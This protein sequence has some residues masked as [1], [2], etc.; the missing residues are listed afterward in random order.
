MESLTKGH[1]VFYPS[2]LFKSNKTLLVELVDFY[3]PKLASLLSVTFPS[4]NLHKIKVI[5]HYESSLSKVQIFSFSKFLQTK[6][7]LLSFQRCAIFFSQQV[8]FLTV[9]YFVHG[10]FVK[11]NSATHTTAAFDF[12]FWWNNTSL[13]RCF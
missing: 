8:A 11:R 6:I 7:F 12:F 13:S 1:V 4:N 2:F 10:M 3:L 9:L 5:F